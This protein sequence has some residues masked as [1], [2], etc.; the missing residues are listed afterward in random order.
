MMGRTLDIMPGE[1]LTPWSLAGAMEPVHSFSQ[2]ASRRTVKAWGDRK[3]RWSSFS[4]QSLSSLVSSYP[5]WPLSSSFLTPQE[6][7]LPIAFYKQRNYS[8]SSSDWFRSQNF[9]EKVTLEESRLKEYATWLPGMSLGKSGFIKAI[10]CSSPTKPCF[11]SVIVEIG[12]LIYSYV[13]LPNCLSF[14]REQAWHLQTDGQCRD[15]VGEGRS[16]L[17]EPWCDNQGMGVY[18]EW[19][20]KH[21]GFWAG[22]WAPCSDMDFRRFWLMYWWSSFYKNLGGIALTLLNPESAHC[23]HASVIL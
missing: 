10:Q 21:W 14:L 11:V 4:R 6:D 20:R 2:A 17:E 13:H 19:D 23:F 18:S 22:A 7:G 9:I 16:N 5:W 15:Q 12:K 3:G 1:G 8:L